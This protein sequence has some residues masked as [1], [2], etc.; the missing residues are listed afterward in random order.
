MKITMLTTVYGKNAIG[1]AEKTAALL[2]QQLVKN[3]HQI[4]II[5]LG[6]QGTSISHTQDEQG[7]EV[8]QI[9]L[10]QIYDPYNLKLKP[11]Q[12]LTPPSSYQKALW[13]L[14]DVY[15]PFMGSQVKK[16]LKQIQPELVL[17]HALQGF[18]V[19]VWRV[20]KSLG[21]KLVHMTH[22]H[23]LICPGTAMTKNAKN[24]EKICSQCSAYQVLRKTVAVQPDAIVGPSEVILKRHA[25]YQWFNS[26]RLQ[27]VIPNAIANEWPL[28]T[29]PVLL[30][31]KWRFGFLGR[32]DESKGLD[33]LLEACSLL[34]ANSFSLQIAGSGPLEKFKK[35]AQDF[36]LNEDTVQLVGAVNAVEFL[37][38]IDILVTPSR[39]FETFSNVV[40]E[41]SCSARPSIVSDRGALPERVQNGK[42]GWIFKAGDAT[43][44]AKVMLHCID[45][46]NEVLAK[47]QAA[48]SMREQYSLEKQ[49]HL[50]ETLLTQVLQLPS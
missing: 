6:A 2:A 36:H 29:S 22:D 46:P 50:F 41:A 14:I 17:T 42:S 24:C 31:A 37:Q 47:S 27:Q 45:S 30:Q 35:M 25:S 11:T 5:S 3:G 38:Q 16:T 23:A 1:G 18:S 40:M 13:H 28:T 21:I 32:L 26:I 9:P 15:N 34:P 4:S 44:L 12:N 19:S 33:T 8:W 10:V 20:V 39:A 49:T 43:D 7:I 48:L